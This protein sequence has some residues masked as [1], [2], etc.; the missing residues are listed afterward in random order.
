MR[1]LLMCCVIPILLMAGCTKLPG[2]SSDI[3]ANWE[4]AHDDRDIPIGS[5]PPVKSDQSPAVGV[6]NVVVVAID[7]EGRHET[8]PVL[9]QRQIFST[10][11]DSLRSYILAA[12]GGKLILTGKVITYV[13]KEPRPEFCNET[14]YPFA[15]AVQEG[16][17]GVLANGID[18]QSID[19]QINI[20]PCGG[21]A[22]AWGRD[23]AVYG[24]PVGTY[25]F[26]HE[27]AHNL[28]NNHGNTY[29]NCPKSGDTVTAPAGCTTVGYGD[30]GN[31]VG[32][33]S[34]LAGA[35]ARYFSGW[36]DGTQFG[37]IQKSG[38]YR[39][40]VLGKVGP[41]GYRIDRTGLTPAELV[42]EYRQPGPYD[43]FPAN[44]NRAKGVWIRYSTKTG[45]LLTTQIDGTP[46]TPVSPWEPVQDPTFLPGQMLKDSGTGITVATCTASNTGATIAVA[47]NG[48]ALPNCAAPLLLPGIQL[49]AAGAPPAQNPIIFSGTS[50]PGALINVSYRL[51]GGN[52]WK[53]VKVVADATG[54]WQ[55][56][57]PDLPAA[58]YN[59]QVRQTM[60]NTASLA[61]FRNFGV[62]P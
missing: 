38:L 25:I 10:D 55:A 16:N 47:V 23:M 52:N 60:G 7:W 54:Q 21:M 6:K 22:S 40:G 15:L 48:E 26:W 49:P 61:N 35:K 50:R 43:L 39:L 4:P 57:L 29:S 28:Y 5:K 18:P 58:D 37:H 13:S 62:A 53:D 2:P 8:D 44:D 14:T 34:F 32:G 1:K 33:G 51:A 56:T 19:Y 20:L 31:P 3:P 42:M 24:Q 41:Q 30:S 27:F 9:L 11:H 12:S 17:K 36:L 59:G 46:E 45:A